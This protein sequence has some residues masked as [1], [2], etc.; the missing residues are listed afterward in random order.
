MACRLATSHIVQLSPSMLFIF[1][2][3]LIPLPVLNKI[4][5]FPNNKGENL[6]CCL[7]LHY[8]FQQKQWKTYTVVNVTQNVNSC[9]LLSHQFS[10]S[11]WPGGSLHCTL[12]KALSTCCIHLIDN[13]LPCTDLK[14]TGYICLLRSSTLPLYARCPRFNP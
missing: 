11:L 2:N 1:K 14:T 13:S 6:Y 8:Q 9:A 5:L 3:L 7:E 10:L 12:L 4:R